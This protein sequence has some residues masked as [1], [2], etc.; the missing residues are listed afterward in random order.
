VYGGMGGWVLLFNGTHTNK[1]TQGQKHQ[2]WRRLV[3]AAG[4]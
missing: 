3:A 2:R 4:Q 1:I